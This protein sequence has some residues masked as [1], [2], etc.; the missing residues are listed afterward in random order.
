MNRKG[1]DICEK[2]KRE[3]EKVLCLGQITAQRAAGVPGLRWSSS[4][5]SAALPSLQLTRGNDLT[6]FLLPKLFCSCFP[7][8]ASRLGY[9]QEERER[10]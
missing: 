4:P 3:K 7:V 8:K 2:L 1:H 5:A 9:S 6:R 10:E